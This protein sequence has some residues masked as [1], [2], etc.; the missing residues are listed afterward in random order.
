M[1]Q[2]PP[3]V[4]SSWQVSSAPWAEVEII[5][6]QCYYLL[7]YGIQWKILIADFASSVESDH[8]SIRTVV[9]Y[10]RLKSSPS[11]N[12]EEIIGNTL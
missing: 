5:V 2:V 10:L 12:G 9:P 4:F 8:N 7:K 3:Y 1:G 11:D 6:T